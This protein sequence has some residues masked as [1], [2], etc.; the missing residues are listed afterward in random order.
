MS[1]TYILILLCLASLW[2]DYPFLPHLNQY[3]LQFLDVGQGDSI[4]IRT[5][6]NCTMLVDGGPGNKLTDSLYKSLPSLE[7]TIDLLVLTH[8]HADHLDGLINILN[9]YE[10]KNIFTSGVT[11]HSSIYT[12]FNK[13]LSQESAHIFYPLAEEEYTLCGL[14][15]Q[16]KYPLESLIGQEIEN[17]NN[18]SLVMRVRIKDSWVY[19]N[20]D[21][22]IEVENEILDSQQKIH[23]DIMKAGHHGSRT[24]NSW[25]ILKA[26]SP[27]E[28]VIQSGLD[29][30][31][32]HPHPETLRKADELGIKVRRNDI[33]GTISYYF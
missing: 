25:D 26:I 20:G 5:P 10:V 9:R 22:E 11:Y 13:I 21:A 2:M 27:N 29:N 31:Y 23:S 19:L 18:A 24:S 30:S 33:R 14:Q 3:K 1:K 28:L 7:N 6:T 4:L 32:L 16:I 8:P 15:I 12:E 17:I